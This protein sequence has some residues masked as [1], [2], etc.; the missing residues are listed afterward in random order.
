VLQP[1]LQDVSCDYFSYFVNVNTQTPK[2][3]LWNSGTNEDA[4][5]DIDRLQFYKKPPRKTV[6]S[7]E[8]PDNIVFVDP[9]G[10][11]LS[12]VDD[13]KYIEG[14]FAFVAAYALEVKR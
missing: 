9:W 11:H 10:K 14:C 7:G 5:D 1:E 4:C 2:K 13:Q 12:P 6:H 8:H 3:N